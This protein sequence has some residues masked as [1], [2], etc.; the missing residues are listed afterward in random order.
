MGGLLSNSSP[1]QPVG[2]AGRKRARDTWAEDYPDTRR[3]KAGHAG[4]GPGI[5]RTCRGDDIEVIAAPLPH[6]SGHL[7]PPRD[8]SHFA[9]VVD[10][11]YERDPAAGVLVVQWYY[12]LHDLMPGTAPE[13]PGAV[14]ELI[15]SSERA[16]VRTTAVVRRV[17]VGSWQGAGAEFFSE[18]HT[19][20][21]PAAARVAPVAEA[22]D[23][24]QHGGADRAAQALI[25]PAALAPEHQT[26]RTNDP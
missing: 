7:V 13:P 2:R 12:R 6:A 22:V 23:A 10:P 26:H 11:R 21:F 18:R 1:T 19:R 16:L 15:E 9:R 17:D 24:R 20:V 4:E 3:P 14:I 8:S 5:L 25:T